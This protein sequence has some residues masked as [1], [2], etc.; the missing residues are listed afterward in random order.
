MLALVNFDDRKSLLK[1]NPEEKLTLEATWLG[2]VDY[3]RC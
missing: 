1:L 3:L 2:R